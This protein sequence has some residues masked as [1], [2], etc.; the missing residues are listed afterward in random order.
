MRCAVTSRLSQKYSQTCPLPSSTAISHAASAQRATRK[1]RVASA[2]MQIVS[3]TMRTPV[4]IQPCCRIRSSG[5][6]THI[7]YRVGILMMSTWT[8]KAYWRGRF[9]F[10]WLLHLPIMCWSSHQKRQ[11]VNITHLPKISTLCSPTRDLKRRTFWQPHI[12]SRETFLRSPSKSWTHRLCRMISISTLWT[13][14]LRMCLLWVSGP[15]CTYGLPPLTKSRNYM[16]WGRMTLWQACNGPIPAVT[17]QW[18]L[19]QAIFRYG[20]QLSAKWSSS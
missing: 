15:A 7:W 10:L 16:I 14:H 11:R 20:T 6:R 12:N 4:Y 2:I 18:V 19:I 13:G 9:H 17:S 1:I 8:A 3:L 5:F